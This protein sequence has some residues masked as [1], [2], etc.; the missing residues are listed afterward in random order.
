LGNREARL[1]SLPKLEL[2]GWL[3]QR[4]RFSNGFG[5]ARGSG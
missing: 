5:L 2:L 1:A 4:A 3:A